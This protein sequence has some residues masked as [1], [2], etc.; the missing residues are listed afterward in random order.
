MLDQARQNMKDD[1]D[2]VDG[3][4]RISFSS[5]LGRNL[6][7]PW[8]DEFME[9]H[10]NVSFGCSNATGVAGKFEAATLRSARYCLNASDY[11]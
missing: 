7:I 10:L 2:T 11:S 4:L 1:L 5:D 6:V 3:E 8:L 9:T